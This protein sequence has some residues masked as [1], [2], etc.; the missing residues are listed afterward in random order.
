MKQTAESYLGMK[1]EKAVVTVPAYFNDAQR[2]ATKDAGTIAGLDV[3]R[4]IN[5]PTAA[6][7]AYGLDASAAA[8][9]EASD[10]KERTVLIFD[11]GGGTFDVS[12]LTIEEGI[13]AVK[14]TAGDTH[15]GGEDFDQKLL[16]YC[17]E[18]FKKQKK[19]DITESAKAVRRLRSACERA[20]R[21][22]SSLSRTTIE[23]DALFEGED[24]RLSVTRAK[25]E[26]L[27]ASL[28]TGTL[29][30]VEQVLKDAGVEKDAV[31]EVVLVGGST[32]VPKIQ[33]LLQDYFGGKKPCSNIN[34]DEA[35]AYGAAV[36]A[37]SLTGK[38]SST[39]E[40]MLLLDVVPLSLG[41]ETEGGLMS[42]VVK[43]NTTIPA[44]KTSMFTTTTN[45]QKN[46]EF[47][48][49]EGERALTKDNNLLGEFQLAGI[50]PQPAGVPE[51]EVT[52]NIDANGI[53]N[54]SAK[55]IASGKQSNVVIENNSSRLSENDI[56]RM[57]K[58]AAKYSTEDEKKKQTIQSALSNDFSNF[59]F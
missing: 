49:Y 29:K 38:G 39:T 51:L 10:K 6:A 26:E 44:I 33:S 11:L 54:V 5:E 52:F 18:T 7:I 37:A 9:M 32:R 25:F 12:L 41:I 17:I 40:N 55:D 19:L 13:F 4:I 48:V 20:K 21:T 45:N 3:L 15:L 34:P 58:D 43:R 59:Q 2:Q 36:Q 53:M 23:V 31:D 8:S 28:F 35:V 56:D 50:L 42:V 22:L 30:P 16:E 47:P 57:I 46:V 24:F 27:C 14:A 1:V